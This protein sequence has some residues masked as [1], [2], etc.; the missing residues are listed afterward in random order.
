MIVLSKIIILNIGEIFYI[1]FQFFPDIA[2]N[3]V[4]TV[5]VLSQQPI[6]LNILSL[7]LS[8][9]F[10][11]DFFI[12]LTKA[13]SYVTEKSVNTRFSIYVMIFSLPTVVF[14]MVLIYILKTLINI[15]F[16]YFNEIVDYL[17]LLFSNQFSQSL[18]NMINITYK[19]LFAGDV[20]EIFIISIFLFSAYSFLSGLEIGKR[21][22]Y[23][24]SLSI[25]IVIVFL[26]KLFA[27]LFLSFIV[28]SP[29]FVVVGSIFAVVVWLKMVFDIILIGAR[30]LYY[31]EKASGKEANILIKSKMS[32]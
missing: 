26:K 12:A 11:K 20:F 29:V 24:V 32:I 31:L 8:I 5:F 22:I 15:L 19:L 1:L 28:K 4:K 6:G 18:H 13:F 23:S 27:S 17:N 3:F 2:V 9:Y 16:R 7:V 21:Y 14:I 30:F 25:G 10:S